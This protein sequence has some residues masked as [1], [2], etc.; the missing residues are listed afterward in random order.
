M[1]LVGIRRGKTFSFILFLIKIGR[2]IDYKV[3]FNA[4]ALEQ[5][6]SD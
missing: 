3:G 4:I 2:F 6:S 5:T 1:F